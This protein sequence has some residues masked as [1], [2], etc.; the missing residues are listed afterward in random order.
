ML[1]LVK[2]KTIPFIFLTNGGGKTEPEKVEELKGMLPKFADHISV[3]W[4]EDVCIDGV[5]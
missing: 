4:V 1:R 2:E 3:M 5:G